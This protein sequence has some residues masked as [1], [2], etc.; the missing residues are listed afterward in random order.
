MSEWVWF[1]AE[2]DS[3]YRLGLEVTKRIYEDQTGQHKLAIYD[4]TA[5]GR[6]MALDGVV[7]I[8]ERDEFIYSEM[9]AHVP[10]LG[11][12]AAEE[13]III[14]GGDGAVL[15][16]VL[17]HR[18]VQ[19]VTL[20]EIDPHVVELCREYLPSVSGAAFD[21]PRTELVFAD[22]ASFVRE[23]DR[24]AD[25]LIIDSTDPIG[26]GASL[27]SAAFYGGCHRCLKPGAVLVTQNGVPFM[28]GDELR[29]SCRRLREFFDDVGCYLTTV[30]TYCGGAMALGW[31]SDDPAKRTVP[32]RTLS[33]RFD[34]ANIIT[35]YYTPEVH[36][37]SFSLP[38]YV[39]RLID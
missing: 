1:D 26:P 19:H 36:A 12:G 11:H 32:H 37:A 18:N 20:V 39:A 17:K 24:R 33:E 28:Q 13:V 21:D 34:A 4:T 27:F 30:P 6:V 15:E 31:A 9:L 3:G 22:G 35:R 29:H 2:L 25:V 10:I 5:F 14:G 23:T 38:A 7:Q 8:T 16:E